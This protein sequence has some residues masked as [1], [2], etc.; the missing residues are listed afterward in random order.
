MS[1]AA[2]SV[3]GDV[4]T[5]AVFDVVDGVVVLLLVAVECAAF[6]MDVEVRRVAVVGFGGLV[7]DRESGRVAGELVALVR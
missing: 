3:R 1:A 6:V 2:G 7:T 4:V 5:S